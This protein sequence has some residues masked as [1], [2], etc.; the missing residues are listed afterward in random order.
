[1]E[2]WIEWMVRGTGQ[3]HQPQQLGVTEVKKSESE[4]D[5]ENE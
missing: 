2:S 5:R 1:M 4:G 3:S